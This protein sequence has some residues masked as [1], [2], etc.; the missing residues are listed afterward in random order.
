MSIALC[1]TGQ[2]RSHNLVNG[3]VRKNL[4]DLYDMDVFCHLWHDNDNSY[5]RSFYC[6][7][8]IHGQY[9]KDKVKEI[10]DFY[11]PTSLKYEKPFIA[12]NTKSM[13]YSFMASNNLKIEY[14]QNHNIE[15]DIVIKSRYDLFF[16]NPL[17]I[18][19]VEDGIIYLMNRPGGCGGYNDW[20]CYGNS[21][22]MNVYMQAYE[23]Y[24]DT[25]RIKQQ[26]PEGIFKEHLDR[27]GIRVSYIN[28]VFSIMR[29]DGNMVV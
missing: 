21:R 1:L 28:R 26:C 11:E 22:T 9:G 18:D 24:K 8:T 6:P 12:E 10:I 7:T 16:T 4:L 17:K 27:N 19:S 3:S 2:I 13:M 23:S 29:E 14:E 25:E 5:Y 15:Y 20:L